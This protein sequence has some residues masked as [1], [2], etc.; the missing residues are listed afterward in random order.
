MINSPGAPL[1]N[2]V[3]R[4]IRNH[5]YNTHNINNINPDQFKVLCT[6]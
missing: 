3:F 2:P 6:L 4:S 1:S 5:V